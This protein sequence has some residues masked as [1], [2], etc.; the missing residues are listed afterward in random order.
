MQITKKFVYK[1]P[2]GKLLR[3][4]V[5][6]EREPNV[7]QSVTITGDFFIYPE[8]KLAL[9]EQ[10]LQHV[11]INQSSIIQAI[12]NCLNKEKIELFGITPESIAEAIITC[13][14]T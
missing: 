2:Q 12:E 11:T 6:L 9:I 3:I 1:V 8:E 5:V 13:T 10:A 7:L 14:Q 4:K